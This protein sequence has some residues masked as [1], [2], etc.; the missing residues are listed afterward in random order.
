MVP[1][2]CLQAA[3]AAAAAART[4]ECQRTNCQAGNQHSTATPPA[5]RN[6]PA[7]L[8]CTVV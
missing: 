6:V 5:L 2:A 3:A 1:P 4:T 7:S 8:L